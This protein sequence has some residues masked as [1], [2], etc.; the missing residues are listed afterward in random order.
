[1]RASTEQRLVLWRKVCRAVD[2][3][4]QYR[5]GHLQTVLFEYKRIH[6]VLLNR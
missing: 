6:E 4:Q 2:L 1:M 5:R 3:A